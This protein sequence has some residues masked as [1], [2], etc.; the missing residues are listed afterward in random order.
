MNTT[1]ITER[2]V[3][4]NL[5]PSFHN[6]CKVLNFLMDN[7]NVFEPYEPLRNGTYYTKTFQKN[8][9]VAER[10]A[11]LTSSF[12][13]FYV[14][15]KEH[16][17]TIIGTVSF[18]NVVKAPVPSCSIGYKFASDFQHHGYAFEATD[19]A[20]NIAFFHM[21]M[22]QINAFIQNENF[23]SLRLIEK[24]GFHV[25]NQGKRMI[26][27]NGNYKGHYKYTLS[28]PFFELTT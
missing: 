11:F 4:K 12:A 20:V 9:L 25:E 3:L 14:F 19:M 27:V 10:K 7:K 8:T 24:L 16:P 26:E 21:G 17:D 2:L 15:L 23:P 1:Y 18:G 22:R 13:R 5:E 6:S 28:H